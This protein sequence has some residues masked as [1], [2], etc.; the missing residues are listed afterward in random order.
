MSEPKI[1]IIDN[2]NNY[3]ESSLSILDSIE[4][5]EYDFGGANP[6]LYSTPNIV[7]VD[8]TPIDQFILSP[9]EIQT[10]KIYIQYNLENFYKFPP[11]T[12]IIISQLISSIQRQDVLAQTVSE[13][14][15]P[16]GSVFF[17]SSWITEKDSLFLNILHE[18]YKFIAPEYEY[19]NLS[20]YN[21]RLAKY[22]NKF[23]KLQKLKKCSIVE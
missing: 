3:T 23:I 11:A 1:Y 15:N 9:G 14:L 20:I 10:E 7:V 12:K 8:I 16:G 5:L 6:S 4:N 19:R 18:E 21:R 22:K 13:S 17:K 2:T